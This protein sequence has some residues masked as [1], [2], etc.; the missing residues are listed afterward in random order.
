VNAADEEPDKRVEWPYR[1]DCFEGIV[2]FP[3]DE[4]FEELAPGVP[5]WKTFYLDPYDPETCER[6]ELGA[7]EKNRPYKVELH[8]NLPGAFSKWRKGAKADLLSGTE[9]EEKVEC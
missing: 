7:L 2:P 8:P 6:D 5:Y 9:K 4:E 3:S 1:I